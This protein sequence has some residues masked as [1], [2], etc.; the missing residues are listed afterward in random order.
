VD[1]SAVL[2]LPGPESWDVATRG[3]RL[4]TVLDRVVLLSM[5]AK[6]RPV[7]GIRIGNTWRDVVAGR[8]AGTAHDE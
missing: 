5:G 4:D 1:R 7:G 2:P 3:L 6:P 8:N